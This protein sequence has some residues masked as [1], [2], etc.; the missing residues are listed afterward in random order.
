MT[1]LSNLLSAGFLDELQILKDA[2]RCEGHRF[3]ALA[4]GGE[5]VVFLALFLIFVCPWP[6]RPW[7][8]RGLRCSSRSILPLEGLRILQEVNGDIAQMRRERQHDAYFTDCLTNRLEAL[9][10]RLMFLRNFFDFLPHTIETAGIGSI[11][12]LLCLLLLRHCVIERGLEVDELPDEE[13]RDRLGDVLLALHHTHELIKLCSEGVSERAA[14]SQGGDAPLEIATQSLILTALSIVF[15]HASISSS[16]LSRALFTTRVA[17]SSLSSPSLS[18]R[19]NLLLRCC[20]PS[21]WLISLSSSESLSESSESEPLPP[22]RRKRDMA[23]FAAGALA[24]PSSSLD[25][26]SSSEE[27]SESLSLSPACRKNRD[28]V[29]LCFGDGSRGE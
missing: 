16:R 24:A 3:A 10:F 7:C 6:P 21:S 15:P 29:F 4:D 26:S 20:W 22:V 23:G 18:V 8:S 13:R 28:I 27:D 19:R 5:R 9:H 25:M 11:H 2:L 14:Y 12:L 1:K 17:S